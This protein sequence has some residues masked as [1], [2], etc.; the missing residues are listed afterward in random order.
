MSLPICPKCKAEIRE[1]PNLEP[2]IEARIRELARFGSRPIMAA[3]EL[4]AAS[5]W[6]L[7]DCK[8]WAMRRGRSCP[9]TD[10]AP[11]P[12]CAK[13]LRTEYEA[14]PALQEGL[15]RRERNP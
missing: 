13:P 8:A 4:R 1:L 15:A 5:G 2:H 9:P 11:C 10:P 7:A 6:E 12:Y 14:M 3:M